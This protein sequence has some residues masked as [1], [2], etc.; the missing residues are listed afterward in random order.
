MGIRLSIA[1]V[2]VGALPLSASQSRPQVA[3]ILKAAA[4]YLHEYS[5]I[6]L[7]AEEDYV[8]RDT[9]T[10]SAPRRLQS[11]IVL[12]G[13]GDGVL[14]G[15]RAIYAVDSS[16]VRERD[17]RLVQLFRGPNPSARQD[18]AR[19]LED[20]LA[21]YYLSPNLRTIDAPGL[22]LEF[23]REA[24]QPKSEFSLDNVRTVG[25][26]QVAQLKFTEK[27]DARI[28]PTPEG[29]KTS[30]KFW[31]DVATG[32]VTQMELTVDHR[33][34]FR[35]HIQTKFVHDSA[36]G[37]WVPSEV[38]QDVEVKTPT[39]NAHSN[40]GAGGQLGARQTFEGRAK[41]TNY[42]KLGS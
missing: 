14:V 15:H 4:S 42:K 35:F 31:V 34:Y 38:L 21:H 33:V 3:D 8:Q 22:A 28:L 36:V 1:L 5:K 25:G 2:L 9:T 11:D 39:K 20:E 10:S 13:L 26:L 16:K 17:G 7:S 41:Y 6:A 18:A 37:F 27:A 23:L 29:S 24:N 19:A 32:A 40:M 12:V 30:G